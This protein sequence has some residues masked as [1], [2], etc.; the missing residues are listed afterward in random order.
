MSERKPPLEIS[1]ESLD[2][3]IEMAGY[4]MAYWAREATQDDEARTYTIIEDDDGEPATHVLSYEKI[5]ETFWTIADC[6]QQLRINGT[7]RAYFYNAVS[8]GLQDGK[9]DIDAGHIDADAADVLMQF[10]CFGEIVYG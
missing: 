5:V 9:G 4:G 3:I 7:I 2:S 10:A 1:Q 8:E 6:W